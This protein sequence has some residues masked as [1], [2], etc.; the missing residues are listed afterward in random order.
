MGQIK[1]NT[2]HSL[3]VIVTVYHS[4][5]K[6]KNKWPSFCLVI[7]AGKICNTLCESKW[8]TLDKQLL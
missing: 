8:V 1:I 2:S 5:T 4:L 7:S 3:R 6:V